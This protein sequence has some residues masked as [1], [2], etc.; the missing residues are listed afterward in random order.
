MTTALPFHP[1]LERIQSL[2]RRIRDDVVR[3]CE[4]AAVAALS[5][6]A[7]EAEGDTIY[8]IDRV[9]GSFVARRFPSASVAA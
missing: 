5:G 3:A 8:V 7:T 9:A 1:L 2:H 6:V 4:E